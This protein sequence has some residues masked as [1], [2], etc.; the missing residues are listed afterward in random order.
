MCAIVLIAAGCN[1]GTPDSRPDSA[2][3]SGETLELPEMRY[4]LANPAGCY[5]GEF[6]HGEGTLKND[7]GDAVPCPLNGY[8]GV[9]SGDGPFPLA[10]FFHGVHKSSDPYKDKNFLG[11]SYLIDQLAAEGYVAISININVEHNCFEYGESVNFDWAYKIYKQ[12]IDKLKKANEG[13]QEKFGIDLKGKVDFGNVNLMGHSRGGY[14]AEVAAHR[15]LD[16]GVNGIRSLLYIAPSILIHDDVS[17]Y[18]NVPISIIVSENDEDVPVDGQTAF[19]FIRRIDGRAD[20]VSLAYLRGGNHAYFSRKM[21]AESGGL[22]REQQ[23]DFLLRYAGTFLSVYSKGSPA[24]GIFDTSSPEPPIMFGRAVQT[25]YMIPAKTESLLDVSASKA[26]ISVSEGASIVYAEQ[27]A[28]I[29]SKLMFN[30]LWSGNMDALRLY[31]IEWEKAGA[32]LSIDLG[33]KDFSDAS[34]L[35]LY[36]AVIPSSELNAKGESQ[37]FT[38]KL[39]DASGK[40]KSVT[41]PKGT[42]AL[43]WHDGEAKHDD[44]FDF[45]YWDGATPISD[46]RVPLSYF[47]GINLSEIS[48]VTLDFNKTG[49][50]AIMLSGAFLERN[51]K[52]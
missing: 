35:S 15:D 42:G 40:S 47:T 36:T 13:G 10:V 12:H 18:P 34:A 21:D 49:S 43:A 6:D 2:Q 14:A 23:E 45:D 24:A 25:S 31:D 5:T 19:E 22:T 37:S 33:R 38:L 39:T 26:G 28:G 9:P 20:P 17:E 30:H 7:L 51:N 3:K 11:A 8:I 50:G 52:Q 46:L 48:S 4:D 1:A 29:G 41:I 27:E 32:S 44:E 16:E